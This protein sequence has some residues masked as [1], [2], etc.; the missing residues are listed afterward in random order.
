MSDYDAA[1]DLL[2]GIDSVNAH[3]NGGGMHNDL[4]VQLFDLATL[5]GDLVSKVEACG[6]ELQSVETGH[7]TEHDF[8]ALLLFEEVNTV[9]GGCKCEMRPFHFERVEDESGTSGTGVVAE[10]VE[11]ADGSVVLHWFNEDNPDLDTTADGFAFKPGP[12][13]L[14]DTLRVHG[15]GGKTHVVFHDG[16]RVTE[17]DL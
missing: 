10:G 7:P 12:D 16:E 14:A 5:D 8:Q 4:T 3:T 13:G 1:L 15:H 2:D 17:D 6:F 11:F 9:V